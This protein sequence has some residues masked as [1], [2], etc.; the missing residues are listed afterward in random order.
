MEQVTTVGPRLSD[1]DFFARVDATRTGLE[2]LPDAVARG[3][4]GAARRIFAAEVR[5]TLQPERFL[6]VR[7]SFRGHNFLRRGESLDQAAARI[8]PLVR[9]RPS[10]RAAVPKNLDTGG[11]S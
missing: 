6:T 11:K 5:R 10:R 3:D 4:L 2:A 7:R 1:V 9:W 8:L